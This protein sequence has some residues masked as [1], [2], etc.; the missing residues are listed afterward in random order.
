MLGYYVP[1]GYT[2]VNCISNS[3]LWY[4]RMRNIMKFIIHWIPQN[5]IR[6]IG[7][8]Y[9]SVCGTRVNTKPRVI[10]SLADIAMEEFI[11]KT[12]VN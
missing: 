12:S 2:S 7:R 10:L 4:S 9:A 8:V 5:I 11:A 3:L 6:L 1:P